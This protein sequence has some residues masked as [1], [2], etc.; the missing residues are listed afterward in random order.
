MGMVNKIPKEKVTSANYENISDRLE[1]KKT[2]SLFG[3]KLPNAGMA[4]NKIEKT[5]LSD[6]LKKRDLRQSY[7]TGDALSGQKQ[8]RGRLFGN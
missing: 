4:V 5:A 7:E 3:E 8:S 1:K 6:F 2:T